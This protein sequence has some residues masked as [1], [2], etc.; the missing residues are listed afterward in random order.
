MS[1]E[2]G[3]YV[4][5][6][7]TNDICLVL[8]EQLAVMNIS[9]IPKA[10]GLMMGL[11]YALNVDYPKHLKYTFEVMQK[12][13]LNVGGCSCSSR[14]NGLRNRLLYKKLCRNLP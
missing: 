4:V 12:L 7:E 5:P 14:V 8:E 1:E 13:F 11:M 3:R 9:D 10:F 6:I 2:I